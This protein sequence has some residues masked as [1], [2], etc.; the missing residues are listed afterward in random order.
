MA[1]WV[2]MSIAAAFL[3]N[4]RSSLQK[5]LT[6][7]LSTQGATATRFLYGLPFALIWL[8]IVFAGSNAPWP[9][10]NLRF[11]SMAAIGGIAQIA[12][13]ALLIATFSH[14]SFAVGTTYSKT[15]GIQTAAFGYLFLGDRVSAGGLVGVVLTVLG[16]VSVSLRRSGAAAG[17]STS[18]SASTATGTT[19]TGTSVGAGA[20]VGT[21]A[22]AESARGPIAAPDRRVQVIAMGLLSGAMFAVSAVCYRGASLA[23]GDGHFLLRAAFT[24]VFALGVQSALTALGLGIFQPGELTRVRRAWRAG[25]LAGASGAGASACWFTAF[26][27]VNASYVKAVGSVELVFAV[28]SSWL[29]FRERPSPTELAGV[30]LVM[31][32]VVVTVTMH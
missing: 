19:G 2:G 28:L 27:L 9:E 17:V 29:L 3:Q 23:L 16:V 14:G 22:G 21:G 20:G 26:T 1:I 7:R 31:L 11:V 12:G 6:A 30:A 24:L 25:L 10:A 13:T 15:E 5:R 4:L 32:G 8:G 18:T